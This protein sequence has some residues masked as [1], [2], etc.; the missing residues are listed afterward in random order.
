[1]LKR[2][3]RGKKG[4]QN[5]VAG[6]KRWRVKIHECEEQL[7]IPSRGMEKKSLQEAFVE[8]RKGN[9]NILVYDPRQEEGRKEAAVLT[10]PWG[11]ISQKPHKRFPSGGEGDR[12]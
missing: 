5:R 4:L 9:D 6:E 3:E 2:K 12:C 8:E 10:K 11:K 1:M 7:S